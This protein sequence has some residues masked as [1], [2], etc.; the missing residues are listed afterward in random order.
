MS[1][2]SSYGK[3]VDEIARTAFVKYVEA[4]S[5]LKQAE[6]DVKKYPQRGGMV[7][8]EYAA[9][10]ARA[11]ADLAGAREALH[12]A[13]LDMSA[14]VNS[15]ANI[16]Q[17]LAAALEAEYSADPEQIDAGVLELLKT[18]ILRPAEYAKL[19]NAA[20]EAGNT[21]M[22]RLIS[23]YASDAAEKAA[24]KYGQSDQRATELRAVAYHGNIDPTGSKLE[25]FDV[26]ME[27]LR[28]T[29]NNPSMISHWG[30]LTSPIIEAL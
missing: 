20:T 15:A 4:E 13:Q 18:G 25:T 6:A 21:T 24:E 2:F 16:R 22:S 14:C 7:D 26:L 9:R 17:E 5:S 23:R 12:K 19:M 10:S 3:R 29:A 1:K 8:Y 28:R 30:E 11:Q 27:A